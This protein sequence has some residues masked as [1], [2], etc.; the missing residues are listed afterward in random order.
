[1]K[2]NETIFLNTSNQ[3]ILE[4]KM[5][6]LKLYLRQ[7]FGLYFIDLN[8]TIK[9]YYNPIHILPVILLQY[10]YSRNS[11]EFKKVR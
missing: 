1:M 2:L 4:D 8:S 6:Y 10:K 7:I 5:K 11:I 9:D 3:N